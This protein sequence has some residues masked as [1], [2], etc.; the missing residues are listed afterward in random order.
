MQK[1]STSSKT[2][3]HK[4]TVAKWALK[5]PF[6]Y[7]LVAN[8]DELGSTTIIPVDVNSEDGNLLFLV[9]NRPNGTNSSLSTDGVHATFTARPQQ[10]AIKKPYSTYSTKQHKLNTDTI[11]RLNFKYVEKHG[12]ESRTPPRPRLQRGCVRKPFFNGKKTCT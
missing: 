3:R 5:M 9:I 11:S 7:V 12:V 1:F 10:R 6:S 2:E 8:E 4:R